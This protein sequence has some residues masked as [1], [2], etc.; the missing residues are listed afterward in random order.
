MIYP[1]SKII[2]FAKAPIPGQVKS[3]L[4]PDIG[5]QAAA[6]LHKEL[7]NHT[8]KT[9]VNAALSQVELWCAPDTQHPF[10]ATCQKQFG[11]TLHA[12]QGA[13]LGER[14]HHALSQSSGVATLLIGSDIPSI[15]AHYLAS[16][17]QALLHGE[18][19]VI[20]PAEDGGYVL[21]GC[22]ESDYRLFSD[23]SWGE[24]DVLSQTMMKAADCGITPSLL[25][26]LWD[27]DDRADL[28]RWRKIEMAAVAP[29]A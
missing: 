1:N 24:G 18:P 20:G 22:R 26:T 28:E 16:A 8:L 19:W 14:M 17:L 21:V 11:V 29:P 23:I 27:V 6:D 2:V 9:A 13:G 3:R 7:L 15:S 12:Q 10:F 4:I 25:K 5:P